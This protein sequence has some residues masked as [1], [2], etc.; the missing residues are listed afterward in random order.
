MTIKTY[1]LAYATIFGGCLKEDNIPPTPDVYM[2]AA[3]DAILNGVIPIT[4]SAFRY[5]KMDEDGL[6]DGLF[7]YTGGLL[8]DVPNRP[9]NPYLEKTT[10]FASSVVNMTA[11]ATTSFQIPSEL[12]LSN[13]TETVLL[14]EIDL[15][16]GTGYQPILFDQVVTANY[17]DLTESKEVKVRFTYTNGETMQA[18]FVFG[19][20]TLPESD[21]SVESRYDD[22]PST[23][24]VVDGGVGNVFSVCEDGAT[25]IRKPFIFVEGFNPDLEALG[26]ENQTFEHMQDQLEFILQD[27]TLLN[28]L[29]DEDYDLIYIDFDD[30]T[31]S[32]QDNA[33]VVQAIIEEINN[34]KA[35]N[36]SLQQNVIFGES[37]GG[38]V[39]KYALL[40]M[41]NSGIDHE[42]ETLM[43]FDSPLRGANIPLSIQQFAD[44]MYNYEITFLEGTIGVT[45]LGSFIGLIEDAGEILGKPGVQQMLINCI[46]HSGDV[47]AHQ[48]LMAEIDAFGLP[49]NFKM[50]AL[51][52]GSNS[53]VQQEKLDGTPLNPGDRMISL[54]IGIDDIDDIYI[55]WVESTEANETILLLQFTNFILSVADIPRNLLSDLLPFISNNKEEFTVNMY[56]MKTDPDE[57]IYD[58][59]LTH[60]LFHTIPIVRRKSELYS[61]PERF[62]LIPVD[63]APGGTSIGGI[64][65][66]LLNL[67]DLGLADID[68][69]NFCFVPTVS[70]LDMV[71]P[72]DLNVFFDVSM[73]IPTI[74]AGLTVVDRYSASPGIV[75]PFTQENQEHVSFSSVNATLFL[76]AL[77]SGNALSTISNLNNIYN[78]GESDNSQ[79][80]TVPF[81]K[82]KNTIERDLIISNDGELWVN[83]WDRIGFINNDNNAEN[84]NPSHFNLYTHL[85]FCN[86]ET[87]NLLIRVTNNGKIILG[88]WEGSSG[89]TANLYLGADTE[90]QIGN[91]GLVEIDDNSKFIIQSGAEVIVEEGG[92][93]NPTWG[94]QLIVEAGGVL[95]IQGGGIL[96]P[97]HFSQV[98]VQPGGQLILDDGA[99]IQLWNG[100]IQDSPN[101]IKIGGPI[102]DADNTPDVPELV[103]GG[104]FSWAGAGFL[105]IHPNSNIELVGDA[106]FKIDGVGKGFRFLRLSEGADLRIPKNQLRLF[107]GEV[108][109]TTGSSEINIAGINAS[110]RFFEMEFNGVGAGTAVTA[111]NSEYLWATNTDFNGFTE[112]IIGTNL[113]L[114]PLLNQPLRIVN[115]TFTDCEYAIQAQ[116][117]SN[118]AAVLVENTIVNSGA[119]FAIVM[120]R[121]ANF[122]MTNLEVYEANTGILAT[123][124]PNMVMRG[125]LIKDCNTGFHISK[126]FQTTGINTNIDLTGGATIQS[127]YLGI[128]SEEDMIIDPFVMVTMDCA[129]LIDNYIGIQGQNIN[130][131]IDAGAELAPNQ[132]S[133]SAEGGSLIFDICY[134][135]MVVQ[136]IQATNNFWSTEKTR[137]INNGGDCNSP[138]GNGNVTLVFEPEFGDTPPEGCNNGNTGTGT[139]SGTDD[140]VVIEPPVLSIPVPEIPNIDVLAILGSC[141]DEEQEFIYQTYLNA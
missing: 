98:W 95:R 26:F 30:P 102:V 63:G 77:S 121:V 94:S 4:V 132:F 141:Q 7:S 74:N 135:G 86:E 136:E 19:V 69:F 91:N 37:M 100:G 27:Q 13:F 79:P 61:D 78:F 75:P 41:E 113:Y 115:C 127:N 54:E 90:L 15:G 34:R 18:H 133:R 11:D 20:M 1:G 125:G 24:I 53:G 21:D 93:L 46:H 73:E 56:A 3:D 49:Q 51:S 97:M 31:A 139:I 118:T 134:S 40:N 106:D 48:A 35:I 32:I 71:P 25:E 83:R 82:T 104:E 38:L 138:N 2:D 123:G 58:F 50:F 44:D 87:E 128:F 22:T 39:S 116:D 124:V 10:F 101:N 122:Y 9:S 92:I 114:E 29:E 112:G 88:E 60:Y 108:E 137:N 105:D 99:I 117:I 5:H 17:S 129:K 81:K 110:G 76:F 33:A 45:T 126:A 43:T 84:A 64:D 119:D 72:N 120:N 85:G 70:A 59:K 96:R 42:T 47:N 103:I 67:V 23:S 6:E 55:D 65:P 140:P 57:K 12:Y 111:I 8:Y 68:A 80:L 36:N 14:I 52:N 62:D 130:L 89:N 28:H 107:N 66:R 16:D 109:Y 131:N